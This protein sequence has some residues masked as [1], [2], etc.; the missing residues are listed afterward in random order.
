MNL[1]ASVMQVEVDPFGDAG[2]P[3]D[4]LDFRKLRLHHAPVASPI[5]PARLDE[6]RPGAY[7]RRK[8]HVGEL[9]QP[10]NIFIRFFGVD[11]GPC[12]RSRPKR[13]SWACDR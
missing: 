10:V 3:V 9:Q 5:P 6:Q 1:V 13:P 4:L 11:K 2:V 8:L 12:S 7:K